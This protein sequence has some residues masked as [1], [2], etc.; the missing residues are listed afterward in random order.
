MRMCKMSIVHVGNNV[1]CSTQH[2]LTYAYT[3]L[4]QF[5]LQHEET[6]DILEYIE[7]VVFQFEAR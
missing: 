7:H 1:V 2:N 4:A 5:G 6:T 3:S